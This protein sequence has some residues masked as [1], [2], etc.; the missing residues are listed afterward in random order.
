MSDIAKLTC[1]ISDAREAV[2]KGNTMQVGALIER[3]LAQAQLGKL[4]FYL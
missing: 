1:L 4:T 2:A 3:A